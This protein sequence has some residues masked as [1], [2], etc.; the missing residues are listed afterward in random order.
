ME[1]RI[2]K[3]SEDLENIPCSIPELVNE[4]VYEDDEFRVRKIWSWNVKS[5]YE[6]EETGLLKVLIKGGAFNC[7]GEST[8]ASVDGRRLTNLTFSILDNFREGL[9]CVAIDGHGYGYVNKDMEFVIPMKY[10][11]AEG[12]NRGR[13]RVELN[14]HFFSIDKTGVEL[15]SDCCVM[16]RNYQEFGHFLEGM[17]RVSVLKLDYDDLEY[18]SDD[19][20]VAGI[21]GFINENGDEIVKPQ[22]IYAYDYDDG[23]AIVAKG[24]WIINQDTGRYYA[25]EEVWGGIN[26]NG[27]EV[28]PCIYDGIKF[29]SGCSDY[30]IAHFGGWEDGAWGV[31]DR[32]GSWAAEPVFDDISYEYRDGLFAFYRSN[33]C[34]DESLMGIYDLRQKR[35]L[36]EPQFL[37]VSF[38]ADGDILVEVYDQR[39]G[40]KVEKIIN[41]NGTERFESEYSSIYTWE[42]PYE[43]MI[44]SDGRDKHGF[45]DKDGTVIV[46]CIYEAVWNGLDLENRRFIFTENG[47]QGVKN[48]DGRTIIPAT[49]LEILGKDKPFL[50][51]RVGEKSYYRE[52]MITASGT[53]VI[54]AEYERVSW[55]KDRKNFFACE[56]GKCEMYLLEKKQ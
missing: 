33:S 55:C 17:C 15:A 56:D 1:N 51:V 5:L 16:K 40:R 53:T 46:P 2:E 32:S 12:F 54:D 26:S 45:I 3:L 10:D 49:Y 18:F 52:G 47:K 7:R 43:V 14:G 36:F 31:I 37:D 4:I 9:S 38:L 50:T 13:A 19:N 35:V 11:R 42:T 30:Y 34:D 28:I 44:R 6:D 21:W 39:L 22:Y 29:Y 25:E 41:R 23:V 24:E 48:F 27:A 8:F 20:G